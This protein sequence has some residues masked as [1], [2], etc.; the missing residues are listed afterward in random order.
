MPV[1]L[2]G[3]GLAPHQIGYILGSFG[4]MNGIFQALFFTK[5]IDRFN[6]RRIFIGGIMLFTPIFCLFPVMNGFARTEN[7]GMLVWVALIIQ[8]SLYVLMDMA[9]GCIFM[10]VTA[11]AP[12]KRSLGATNG[13][14]QTTVS[15]ARA[16]G[17]AM[18]TSLFS[19]S[20][21]YKLFG[22]NFVYVFLVFLSLCALTLARQLPE[23]GWKDRCEGEESK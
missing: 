8:L 1:A 13:L 5:I 19:V 2:G 16:I 6:P 15:I 14:A 20:K 3:L 18:A 23:N 17:P 10:F 21:E 22:G 4:A 12:N 9:Y 7:F 11:A